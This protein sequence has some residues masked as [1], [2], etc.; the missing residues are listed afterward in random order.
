V[1]EGSKMQTPLVQQIFDE[2]FSKIVGQ[3]EFNPSMIEELKQL[4]ID[5]K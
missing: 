3:D 2:M 4:V 5:A 1:T